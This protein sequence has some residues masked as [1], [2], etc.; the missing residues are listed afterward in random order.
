MQATASR[1]NTGTSDEIIN[2]RRKHL[3]LATVGATP[4]HDAQSEGQFMFT[5]KEFLLA[6]SKEVWGVQAD[7]TLGE[8]LRL[9]AE[10]GVGA[11]PVMEGGKIVGIFSE[12]DL[13]RKASSM[14]QL[15]MEIPIK[16]FTTKKVRCVQP[17]TSMEECMA[18]MT[19][20][21]VRHLP[22]MEN[23][24]L[25]GIITIGDAVKHTIQEQKFILRKVLDSIE[26]GKNALRTNVA[27]NVEQYILPLVRQLFKKHPHDHAAFRLLEKQL[28][29]VSSESYRKLVSSRYNFTPA[30]ISVIKLI[31][32]NY[33]EKEIS[34][35]LNISLSTVK[36]HKYAI[37]GKLGIRNQSGNISGYLDHVI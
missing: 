5:L 14:K 13:A 3:R 32:A 24:E 16:E 17:H 10:K 8:A 22:I 37:R 35:A 19:T 36:K 21:R 27:F 4:Y 12:R 15:S 2:G 9:M 1:I 28:K 18:I 11:V 31:R 34:E 25:V 20:Q 6:K 29:E 23:G 30:E 33:R 7:A 26:E